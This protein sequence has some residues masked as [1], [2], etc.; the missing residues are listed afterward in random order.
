MEQQR[1]LGQRGGERVVGR[2]QLLRRLLFGQ[3][4]GEVQNPQEVE[5]RGVADRH[6]ARLQERRAAQT[7]VT[8]QG[9]LRADNMESTYI[10]VVF[11][12]S[13]TS[14]SLPPRRGAARRPAAAGLRVGPPSS[15][16]ARLWPSRTAAS[17]GE[18][19]GSRRV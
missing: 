6:A 14:A 19:S 3:E 4:E 5:R 17:S 11:L 12:T 1:V 18:T 16:A 10:Q 9:A 13:V 8:Q 7:Q 15:A 2:L